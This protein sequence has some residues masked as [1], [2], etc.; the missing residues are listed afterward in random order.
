MQSTTSGENTGINTGFAVKTKKVLVV[1][2]VYLNQVLLGKF[3]EKHG[4]M[5][6]FAHNGREALDKLKAEEFDLILMDLQMPVMDGYESIE[7]IRHDFAPPLCN[8]P[9]IGIS[10]SVFNEEFQRCLDV[11]AND[12]ISKPYEPE[13]LYNKIMKNLRMATMKQHEAEAEHTIINDSE[14]LIDLSYLEQF[15]GG[16]KAFV[17]EM[18]TYFIDHTPET[19][20][21]MKAC[22]T[23]HDYEKVYHHAHKYAPQLTFMGIKSIVGLVERIELY[24]KKRENI[25]KIQSL[26]ETVT[27]VSERAIKELQKY[28]NT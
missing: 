20:A 18:I 7:R 26:I 10:A 8:I 27:L 2:D 14:S 13:D 21:G 23:A 16:D 17:H 12:F 11:G 3:L 1:D 4:M 9:I 24:A 22:Y 28:L 25:Q 19:L 6:Q 15:S 5:P